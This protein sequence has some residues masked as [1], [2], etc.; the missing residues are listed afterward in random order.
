MGC[1]GHVL[2]RSAWK[3]RCPTGFGATSSAAWYF[4]QSIE[5]AAGLLDSV[6]HALVM[7]G[8]TIV[9]PA[10]AE[11]SQTRSTIVSLRDIQDLRVVERQ[12]GRL[13]FGAMATLDRLRHWDAYQHSS[14][15]IPTAISTIASPLVRRLATIGGNLRWASGAGDLVPVLLALD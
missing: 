4:P 3:E 5:E 10:L 1:A 11:S 9:G 13:R 7:G 6:P 14:R 12:G 15:I 8:G 2:L